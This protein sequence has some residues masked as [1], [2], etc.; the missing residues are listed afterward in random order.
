MKNGVNLLLD[1][2]IFIYW[3]TANIHAAEI[4]AENDIHFSIITEIEIKGHLTFTTKNQKLSFQK[5]LNRFEKIGL[6][7]EIKDFAIGYK[8]LYNLKTPDAIIAATAKSLKLPLVTGDK[9]LLKVED[10]IT[11]HF[12]PEI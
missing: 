4:L 9:K 11:V 7:E 5:V 1:S 8:I 3:L 12:N 6:T 10:I 2:N